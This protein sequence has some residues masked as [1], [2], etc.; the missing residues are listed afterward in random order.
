MTKSTLKSLIVAVLMFMGFG[1]LPI[2]AQDPTHLQVVGLYPSGLRTSVTERWGE[3]TFS[4]RNISST[5]RTARVVAYHEGGGVREVRPRRL[6][7]AQYHADDGDVARPSPRPEAWG[8][9]LLRTGT[10]ITF[11]PL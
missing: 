11:H 6:G 10:D 7:A 8:K 1:H 2:A 9:S 3:I 4:V 5:A